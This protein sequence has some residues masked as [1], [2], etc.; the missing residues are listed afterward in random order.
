MIDDLGALYWGYVSP[1]KQMIRSASCERDSSGSLRL[2]AGTGTNVWLIKVGIE[3]IIKHA[4]PGI[5]DKHMHAV[6]G[7]KQFHIVSTISL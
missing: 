5:I 3:V 6:P 4:D 1:G 2:P 7:Q